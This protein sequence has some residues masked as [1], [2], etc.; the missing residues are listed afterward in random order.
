MQVKDGEGIRVLLE[1]IDPFTFFGSFNR[2][3]RIEN[4]QEILKEVANLF[5]AKNSVPENFDGIPI[6]NNQNSRFCH[7]VPPEYKKDVHTLWKLFKLALQDNPLDNQEFIDVLDD[8]LSIEGIGTN[9]TQGLFWIRPDVFISFDGKNREYLDLTF[10]KKERSG[11][12]Y[13]ELLDEVRDEYPGIPFTTIS[14]NAWLSQ[15]ETDPPDEEPEEAIKQNNYWLVGAW[16]DEHD[17]L[18]QTNRFVKEGIWANGYDNKYR[19]LVERMQPG[20]KIAIKACATQKNELPF[21]AKGNTASKMIIK[22]RGIITNKHVDGK[23]VDVEWDS[24]FKNRDWYFYTARNTVWRLQ[25]N[26]DYKLK[27]YVGKLID[28]IWNDAPQDYNWFVD[29][30]GWNE[31]KNSIDEEEVID[32]AFIVE[33]PDY[34]IDD[35]IND[36]FLSQS[37]FTNIVDNLKRKKNIILQG[38]PGVGKTYIAN[39]L[40]YLLMGKKDDSRVQMVQFHQ[41]YSY[42]DFVQGWRPTEKGGFALRNGVFFSFCSTAN[43]S[44][45]KHVFIIDE[46]N[47]GNLSKIFGELMMLIESDKRGP[48]FSI[49]LTYA[50]EGEKEFH[51]PENVY[52]MGLMNTADRSLAMVDYA[53]RRRFAFMTLEPQ[54]E[55]ESF[56]TH[57]EGVGV[58][59]KLISRIISRLSNLNEEIASDTKNLG[60]GYVIG[61]SFFCPTS[62]VQVLDDDWYKEIVLNEVK[63]LLEEYWFDDSKKADNAVDALLG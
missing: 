56:R 55:S 17:P 16:W 63:P 46:I 26:D 38:P 29:Q 49:P 8:A 32:P 20:D 27:R 18:D 42:E 61:P 25:V 2:G 57:L 21:D 43:K 24:N 1:D 33:Y 19:D 35:A 3:I 30:W 6:L 9:I 15:Q 34:T 47:R 52:V 50:Q 22:A 60:P 45:E 44:E 40:A 11:K 39:R 62:K 10:N 14:R 28:F 5:G 37:E 41:S 12:K 53:L 48:E 59:S 36:V 7:T 4:R 54:F 13:K 31:T 58:N 51:V 23:T